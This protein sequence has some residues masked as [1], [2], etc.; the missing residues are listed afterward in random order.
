MKTLIVYYSFSH[1]NEMLA[2]EIKRETGGDLYKIEEKKRR[3]GFTILL[4]LLFD[5][6]PAIKAAAVD[7]GHYDLC[8]FL[9]PVWGGKIGSP[10]RAFLQNER[11]RIGRYAFITVCGG[12]S[13]EQVGK[14]TNQLTS[15]IGKAPEAVCELWINDLLPERQRN[16]IKYTS[17]YRLRENDMMLFQGK[18]AGFLQ[19]LE[20]SVPLVA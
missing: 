4:D 12:G 6:T 5:R 2:K 11:D 1:N 3:N 18:I 20:P 8:I 16:T 17:G 15:L 9:A 7:P 14:V 13:A 19:K 10:L